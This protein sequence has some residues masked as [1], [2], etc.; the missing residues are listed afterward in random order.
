MRILVSGGGFVGAYAALRLER[1]LRGSGHE[2]VLV[3]PENY[4]Q[5]QPF[6]PEAASGN[7]EP[8]H[9]VVP[10]REVLRRTRLVV[11]EVEAI[12]HGARRA[13]IRTLADEPLDLQY[14]ALVLAPGS[15][16]RVLPV[17]GLADR[18]IGFKTI[19]E[20]IHLR[21]VVLSR[22]E[23]AADTTDPEHRRALLT[24]VFVGGGYAG[25][26]ALA[27]LEDL[28]R[29][30]LRRY[31]ELH[32]VHPRWVLVE[33]AASL[34]PELDAGLARYAQALLARRGVDVRLETRLDS[35]EGGVMRLSDG[36]VFAAETLVWTTGVR[37][38]PLTAQTGFPVDDQGRIATDEYLRVLDEA[39]EAIPGA[40]AAGDCAA[41]PDPVTGR[42]CPPTAQHALRQARC[43]ADNLVA[44][45]E[46]RPL[47]RFRYR[48]RGQL[49]SLGRYRGVAQLPG[50]IRIR[51]FWAWWL[52]RTY[53]LAMMPTLNRRVRIALDWTVTLLFPRDITAL[54]SL[55]RPREAFERAAEP[56]P[57]TLPESRR[58]APVTR[59]PGTARLAR[60]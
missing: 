48:N 27:E 60:P 37:P 58:R 52:H 11:G 6:L 5:Y 14:D 29:A 8:R 31:P 26:E 24:F 57:G 38:H 22:L 25:V 42:P 18:A 9:V 59:D 4:L 19:A 47:R 33:A 46:G 3:N 35:A 40:W 21:N 7:I 34:L 50:R 30:A 39:G 44:T 51:G 32:D 55:Q 15:V 49:V 12:D 56:P 41:V 54:G 1:R 13:R 36:D 53:H 17:P 20:A 2:V 16:S 10:L 43:L 45:I 23:A 28:V